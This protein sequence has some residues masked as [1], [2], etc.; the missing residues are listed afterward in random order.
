MKILRKYGID[1]EKVLK[2]LS[3]DENDISTEKDDILLNHVHNFLIGNNR[4]ALESAEKTAQV[5]ICQ[6]YSFKFHFQLVLKHQAVKDTITY[7]NY[8]FYF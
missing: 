7:L 4:I 3:D 8:F 5:I 2:I 1:N 6:H